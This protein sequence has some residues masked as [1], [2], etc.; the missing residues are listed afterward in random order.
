MLLMT[1]KLCQIKILF[2]ARAFNL[3]LLQFSLLTCT[4]HPLPSEPEMC[5]VMVS[6]DV[7]ICQKRTI[8]LAGVG[9]GGEFFHLTFDG[10]DPSVDT[11]I[12][13]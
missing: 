10:K 1:T 5:A 12:N 9:G 6:S 8:A 3:L 2:L 4:K 7:V 11:R 13:R